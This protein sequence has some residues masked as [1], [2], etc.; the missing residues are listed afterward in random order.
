M[1]VKTYIQ[2]TFLALIFLA[3]LLSGCSPEKRLTVLLKNNPEL[4]KAIVEEKEVIVVKTD[5]FFRPG[6]MEVFIIDC[7]SIQTKTENNIKTESEPVGFNK[8]LVRVSTK[9]TVIFY[10]DTC[11]FTYLDSFI[12]YK[13]NNQFIA[14]QLYERTEQLT[15][16][17]KTINQYK[18]FVPFPKICNWIG[19]WC[20]W[21]F[22][23]VLGIIG[24]FILKKG[25]KL[26]T[27]SV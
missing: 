25:I 5:S 15:A 26:I 4:G 16:A 2:I 12:T 10:R 13:N 20:K 8:V 23:F 7:D 6:E 27:K 18:G 24:P 9:D 11:R 3:F 19:I 1:K 14:K 22:W 21:W 17:L